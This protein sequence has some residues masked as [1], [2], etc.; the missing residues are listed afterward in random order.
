MQCKNCRYWSKREVTQTKSRK[1]EYYPAGRCIKIKEN[2]K[3]MFTTSETNCK[4]GKQ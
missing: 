1:K 2:Y 4:L 3:P